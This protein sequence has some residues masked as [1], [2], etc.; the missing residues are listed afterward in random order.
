MD[1]DRVSTF[2]ILSSILNFAAAI[3]VCFVLCYQQ[4]RLNEREQWMAEHYVAEVKASRDRYTFRSHT[5]WE[6]AFAAKNGLI[7]VPAEKF[8]PPKFPRPPISDEKWQW[9]QE[10][11]RENE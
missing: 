6:S 7:T 10:Q 11:L 2:S 1:H 5:E 8:D 4:A 9:V 3:V